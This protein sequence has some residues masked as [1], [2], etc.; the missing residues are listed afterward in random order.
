MGRSWDKQ[1][2]WTARVSHVAILGHPPHPNIKDQVLRPAVVEPR[3][4]TSNA[5]PSVTSQ[6]LQDTC[7]E[8]EYRPG[9]LRAVSGA[10]T[11]SVV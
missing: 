4:R 10:Q 2:D 1:T 9:I 7:S 8:I 5:S 3:T 6:M 11:A